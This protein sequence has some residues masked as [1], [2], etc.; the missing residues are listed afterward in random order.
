MQVPKCMTGVYVCMRLWLYACSCIFLAFMFAFAQEYMRKCVVRECEYFWVCDSLWSWTEMFQLAFLFH[1]CFV[2]HFWN[3]FVG[4]AYNFHLLI[5]ILAFFPLIWLKQILEQE[6]GKFKH[7][8]SHTWLSTVLV[9]YPCVIAS[10]SWVTACPTISLYK[11]PGRIS[12]VLK[13]AYL[14][15][16]CMFDDMTQFE[17]A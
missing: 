5:L 13:T 3:V 6:R 2:V 1:Y 16:I 15:K 12:Y 4:S 9:V 7:C 14:H 11:K 10:I 17:L 8:H